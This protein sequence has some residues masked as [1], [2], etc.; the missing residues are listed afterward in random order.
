[1]FFFLFHIQ[2][3]LLFTSSCKSPVKFQ[4][5]DLFRFVNNTWPHII[6]IAP[7]AVIPVSIVPYMDKIGCQSVMNPT[8]VADVVNFRMSS[9]IRHLSSV[10][11]LSVGPSSIVRRP[12]SVGPLSVVPSSVGPSSVVRRSD[13]LPINN[14]YEICLLQFFA[15]FTLSGKL[16]ILIYVDIHISKRIIKRLSSC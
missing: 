4:W 7:F 6:C 16:N 1:M 12:S 14:L 15:H 10:G 5:G 13:V 9:V 3:R 11:P 2:C 8:F